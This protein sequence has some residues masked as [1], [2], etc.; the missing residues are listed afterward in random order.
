MG[1]R[2]NMLNN[3]NEHIKPSSP[4][5]NELI[6]E[7]KLGGKFRSE[8]GVY[9]WT[10]PER[11]GVVFGVPSTLEIIRFVPWSDLPKF[12]EGKKWERV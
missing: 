6:D 12:L 1:S 5:V 3:M 8:D 7:L 2:G 4:S 11:Q 9:A 10:D